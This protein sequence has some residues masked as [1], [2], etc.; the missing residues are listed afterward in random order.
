[1]T[2]ADAD[3]SQGEAHTLI[4]TLLLVPG[5]GLF[6]AMVWTLNRVV[7]EPEGAGL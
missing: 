3:L 2:L 7:R 6:M 5:L 4:G 1:M